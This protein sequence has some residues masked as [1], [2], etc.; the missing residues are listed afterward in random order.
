MIEVI[1][2]LF[3]P[4]YTRGGYS[5]AQY[6]TV[7]KAQQVGELALANKLYKSPDHSVFLMRALVGLEGIITR[8]GVKDDYRIIFQRCVERA[9][10][11]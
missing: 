2:I 6:D 10:K 1:H 4:M 9:L 7:G 3:E 5:P 11:K 8:L